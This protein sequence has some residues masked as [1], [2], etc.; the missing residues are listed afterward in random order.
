MEVDLECP[1]CKTFVRPN[2][3][4]TYG[5]CLKN[6]HL[7][8]E[9]CAPA[10]IDS[11]NPCPLCRCEP[12]QM[13]TRF[14]LADIVLKQLVEKTIYECELCEGTFDWT[15]IVSHDIACRN[16]KRRCSLCKKLIPLDQYFGEEHKCLARSL[17]CRAGEEL[18]ETSVTLDD[19]LQSPNVLAMQLVYPGEEMR[20][21][22]TLKA[23]DDGLN[24]NV[25]MLQMDCCADD[26]YMYPK[27]RLGIFMHTV[28]GPLGRACRGR[29]KVEPQ[30]EQYQESTKGASLFLSNKLTERWYHH[31]P[32]NPCT[33]CKKK[34]P[35]V[36]ITVGII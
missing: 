28:A 26:P 11:G 17:A 8:C 10:I 16:S 31:A 4:N 12:F 3:I 33:K 2:K 13:E 23:T 36:H 34:T 35:H 5:L 9:D 6:H 22:L 14:R 7:I 27:V 20:A 32:N 15:E 29:M 21:L 1:V 18:W 25:Y 24:I 30:E 19:L